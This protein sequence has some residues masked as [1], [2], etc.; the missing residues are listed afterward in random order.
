MEAPKVIKQ[1][2]L[3]ITQFWILCNPCCLTFYYMM[4]FI[5]IPTLMLQLCVLL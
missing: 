3:C 5:Q 2:E 1:A 4:V